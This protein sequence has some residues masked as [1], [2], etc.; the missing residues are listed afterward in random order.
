MF[1]FSISSSSNYKLNSNFITSYITLL[2]YKSLNK[3]FSYYYISYLSYYYA[4]ITKA[5]ISYSK[6]TKKNSLK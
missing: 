1:L 5:F 6:S 4:T 2:S 3:L